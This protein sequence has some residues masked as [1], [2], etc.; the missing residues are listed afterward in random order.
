MA[1]HNG[2]KVGYHC[3]ASGHDRMGVTNSRPVGGKIRRRRECPKC[4]HR[5]TT[6]EHADHGTRQSLLALRSDV[7][8]TLARLDDILGPDDEDPSLS[9]MP[10][11]LM[12]EGE[13]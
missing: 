10:Q 4:G 11:H 7:R 2:E 3:P 8:A 6:I 12:L 5:V 13:G 1:Q 9:P